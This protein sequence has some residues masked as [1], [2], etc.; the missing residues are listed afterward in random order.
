MTTTSELRPPALALMALEPWRAAI[1]FTASLLGPPPPRTGDGHTVLVLPGLAAGD[2]S[3][4]RLRRVLDRAGFASSDW[5]L[6]MNRG[7]DGDIDD[8]LAGLEARLRQ[9]HERSGRSVSLIGWSLG[10]IYA[11]E[12]A[13]RAPHRVRQ[14]ITLGSPFGAAEASRAGGVFRLVNGGRSRMTPELQ[15]R[16]REDPPVPTTAI[17]TR[18]DGVVAWQGCMARESDRSENIEVSCASHCGLGVHPRA[19]RIMVERL[20]QPEDGWRRRATSTKK[21]GVG[22]LRPHHA[23]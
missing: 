2:W 16:L 11:R 1:D 20:S 4:L 15:Q 8:W 21:A 17:F 14:V 5:G 3:T 6:G 12:L 7:P 19:V 9:L 13:K 10:G 22:G 18:T 23:L